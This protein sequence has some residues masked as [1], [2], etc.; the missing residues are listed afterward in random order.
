MGFAARLVYLYAWSL[1]SKRKKKEEKKRH[2]DEK[3][4]LKLVL[5]KR[6]S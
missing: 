2:A 3:Q 1:L 4:L 5:W 6:I